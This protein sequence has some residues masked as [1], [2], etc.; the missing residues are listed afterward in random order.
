[1]GGVAMKASLALFLCLLLIAS[2]LASPTQH[3]IESGILDADFSPGEATS[4]TPAELDEINAE[5]LGYLSSLGVDRPLD[6]L[7]TPLKSLDHSTGLRLGFAQTMLFLQPMGGRSDRYGAAGDTDFLSSWTLLGRETPD[8]GRLVT[9]VEYRY[10]IGDQPPSALGRQI[11]TLIPVTNGFNDRGWVVRDAY[12]IQRL[13]DAR[14]RILI[15]RGY[16]SD[17]VGA[18]WLQN[19]NNSFVNRH[20]SANPSI[21]FPG[22]GP[23]CGIS[24][25]PTDQC[26]LTGGVSNAY[27]QATQNGFDTLFNEWSLFS[28]AE[29]GYTPTFPTLG[30][31][32]YAFGA[33]HMDARNLNGL[34]S[35]S[36]LCAI[37]D[38]NLGKNLQTFARY[39]YSDG[40]LTN[41][42][43][44][45]QLGFGL[46]GMIGRKEDLTGLAYSLAVPRSSNSRN[47]SVIE[48]FHR[49][50][51]SQNSQL[52]LGVQLI[53]NPG[54]APSNGSEG[55]VTA[56]FR[57]SF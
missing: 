30:S 9:T 6:L 28:F 33:W 20:F 35:D 50:Q 49:F 23:L 8:T 25:R 15:G 38:Q 1:M 14:L 42:R 52:S 41:V 5:H 17:Y 4:N 47:E 19:V 24:L 55:I 37:I 34:P 40:I 57:A 29:A 31:G 48:F 46:S 43:Q 44:L 11:G 13:F 7:T 54:N 2:S 12:W 39:A 32:R 26:Y 18:Y 45:A 51:V 56:R 36:G 21:P 3:D 27:G 53:A 10:T 22:H 16:A